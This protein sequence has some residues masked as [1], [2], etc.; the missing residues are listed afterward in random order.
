VCVCV[1]VCEISV[2]D[3]LR[4]VTDSNHCLHCGEFAEL[5]YL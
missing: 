5:R 2:H 3:E 4:L 1:S